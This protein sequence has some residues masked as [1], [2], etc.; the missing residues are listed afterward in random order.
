MPTVIVID[1]SVAMGSPFSAEINSGIPKLDL[2]IQGLNTFLDYLAT[3]QKLEFISLLSFNH[4]CDVLIPFTRDI[5]GIKEKLKQL[6]LNISHT[7]SSLVYVPH[8]IE[9]MFLS[10]WDS[11][12]ECNILMITQERLVVPAGFQIH[13]PFPANIMIV[14][15]MY[16]C[17]PD[18]V[19][20]LVES[21][22]HKFKVYLPDE[23]LSPRS[24]HLMF[25]R[26]CEEHFS[27]W[28][29]S[30]TCG[31]LN[32]KIVLSPTPVPYNK[33]TDFDH[34]K[35][36]LD[37]VI[38]ICGFIEMQH[39]GSPGAVSRH[40]VLPYSSSMASLPPP[41]DAPKTDVMRASHLFPNIHG[42]SQS[43]HPFLPSD[44]K[45]DIEDD[46][47]GEGH[48]PSFCVLLHGALKVENMA[49]ICYVG[50][51]WYGILYSWADSKKK[52]NLMLSL[53]EP[54]PEPVPWL[55]NLNDLVIPSPE[56]MAVCEQFPVKPVARRVFL[57]NPSS[58]IR[59]AG[60]QADIQKVLRHARKL[61]D[62]TQQ[63]FK[64]LNRVRKAALSIGF[65]QLLEGLAA[66]L[67]RECT[68]LPGTAHPSC[69]LQL[70]HAST[71]LKE[72][73]SLD[74]RY[75]MMPLKMSF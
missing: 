5:P 37:P 64:E 8:V 46:I 59:Q 19:G 30:L 43:S 21:S 13:F 39:I 50:K 16:G 4:K 51:D 31:N 49:A 62:K 53:L 15:V 9:D 68:M 66:I 34:V 65:V 27:P 38:E 56:E 57:P 42:A 24:Y 41:V 14:F 67:E 32:A 1:T 2:A 44:G 33:L 60:L 73:V 55:G 23:P 47:S 26:M 18:Y 22:T 25:Y 6:H 75:N 61:P 70:S 52:S 28:I 69:A 29:G 35:Y 11:S 45:S 54:G 71:V 12:T 3:R 17:V 72:K 36:S 48:I 10:E 20:A 40:L 74:I 7:T 58:W 63:F